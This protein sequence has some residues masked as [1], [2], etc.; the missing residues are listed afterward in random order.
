MSP[1]LLVRKLNAGPGS[2][3]M[4][5][6]TTCWSIGMYFML[7]TPFS[8]FSMM[9]CLSTSTCLVLP[10]CPC[11]YPWLLMRIFRTM[12]TEIVWDRIETSSICLPFCPFYLL[13]S[14]V[15][16]SNTLLPPIF[17][18]RMHSSCRVNTMASLTLL[19]VVIRHE[20]CWA[21]WWEHMSQYI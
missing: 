2:P 18:L 6:S 21:L 5:M 12:H 14:R 13:Q 16:S 1:S 11:E 4:S 20:L 3:F 19:L 15:V 10:M 7:I 17:H 9:K 8:S